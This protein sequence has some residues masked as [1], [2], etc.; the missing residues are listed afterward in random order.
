EFGD[1]VRRA[2]EPSEDMPTRGI[3]DVLGHQDEGV[4]RRAAAA[5]HRYGVTPDATMLVEAVADAVVLVPGPR[6][7]PQPVCEDCPIGIGGLGPRLA[8][9]PMVG[10][11]QRDAYR[12]PRR[13]AGQ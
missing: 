12:D 10:L 2:L 3:G 7:L 11:G 8:K 1:A 9:R 5:R 4:C 6:E 13:Q